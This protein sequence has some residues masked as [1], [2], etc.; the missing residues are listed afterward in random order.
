MRRVTNIFTWQT[1][2]YLSGKVKYKGN[3]I[4][5]LDNCLS[6]IRIPEFSENDIK[7]IIASLNNS[8]AGHANLSI[9]ILKQI[10][11]T[12]IQL[13]T[14][15]INDSWKN[16]ILRDELKIAKVIPLYKF[17]PTFDLM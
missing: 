12:Y 3:H 16:G 14:F 13:L 5:Y 15:L 8:S 11:E 10:V 6:S 4:S 1:H 17:G 7:Q 9:S 2:K